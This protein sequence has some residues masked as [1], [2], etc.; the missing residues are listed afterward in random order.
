[1]PVKIAALRAS[2]HKGPT[3]AGTVCKRVIDELEAFHP[4][5][6]LAFH[7]QGDLNGEWDEG[8]LAQVISN[9]VGNAQ[10][11]GDVSCEAT[12]RAASVDGRVVITVHNFGPTI[13]E[14]S[15]KTIFDPMV[16]SSTGEDYAGQSRSL[17]LGLFIVRELV[18]AHGGSV[19][20]ASADATGTTFT[21]EL[22][23]S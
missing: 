22:P 6:K 9:L 1:V 14:A 18:N 12:V 21:V 17:G 7:G 8:R 13:P 2:L 23:R 16:R 19:A 4:D 3:N 15:L 11:H 5:R 10:Q 20:V